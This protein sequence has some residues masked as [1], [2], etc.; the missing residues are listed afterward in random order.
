MSEAMNKKQELFV[1]EY[2]V[3]LNA[4]LGRHSRRLQPP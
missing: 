3:D 4:T 1:S 2:L